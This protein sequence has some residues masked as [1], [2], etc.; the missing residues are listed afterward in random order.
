MEQVDDAEQDENQ[1]C[2]FTSIHRVYYSVNNSKNL[3]YQ[4]F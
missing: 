1:C 4:N 2:L 3:K